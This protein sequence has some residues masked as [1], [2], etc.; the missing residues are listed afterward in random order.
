MSN[1]PNEDP[2]ALMARYELQRAQQRRHTEKQVAYLCHALRFLGVKTVTVA[3]DAYG[4]EGSIK[5]A[6]F[7]P[8]IQADLP[9]G[10][11][12]ALDFNWTSFRTT[13][14]GWNFSPNAGLDGTITIDVA[15]GEVV[16]Q[17][18][19]ADGASSEEME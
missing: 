7:E 16:E 18:D 14:W 9:F 6:V 17:F 4:D 1:A 19:P 5:E 12:E 13:G 8:P 15:T 2:E 3:F 10:L 11:R